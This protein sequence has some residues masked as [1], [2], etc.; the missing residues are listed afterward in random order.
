[1]QQI[2]EFFNKKKFDYTQPMPK[3]EWEKW[4]KSHEDYKDHYVTHLW[5]HDLS[6]AEKVK[7]GIYGFYAYNDDKDIFEK[8]GEYNLSTETFSC[9]KKDAK[10][11]FPGAK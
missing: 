10:K 7:S 5:K 6:T 2:N 4:V 11:Y 8:V 1:M 3:E 9:Y